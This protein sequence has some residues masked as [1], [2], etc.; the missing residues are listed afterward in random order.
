M[1]MRALDLNLSSRPF[2]N[3]TLP[4]AVVATVGLLLAWLSFEN[5]STYLE[6]KSLAEDLDIQYSDTREQLAMLDKKERETQREIDAR[7]LDVLASRAETANEVLK[8]KGFSWTRL[9]NKM[10]EVL[11]N[12]VQMTSVHPVFKPVNPNQRDRRNIELGGRVPVDVEGTAKSVRA[13]FDFERNLTEHSSF[14]RVEP[15]ATDTERATKTVTFR[16]KFLYDPAWVDEAEAAQE[17]QEAAALAENVA[18][19]EADEPEA[20]DPPDMT[21]ETVEESSPPPVEASTA[22]RAA[23]RKA[24]VLPPAPE[25]EAPAVRRMGADPAVTATGASLPRRTPPAAE[26]VEGDKASRR[27]RG[28]GRGKDDKDKEGS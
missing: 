7:D 26:P 3:N 1:A 18:P 19:T 12:D 13:F 9:F 14:H 2:R 24:P 23:S 10:E 11:P 8:W 20:D 17:A 27:R 25:E 16:L 4:W 6:T 22:G 28:R 5:V 15:E 21:A